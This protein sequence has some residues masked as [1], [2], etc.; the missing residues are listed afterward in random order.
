M[1]ILPNI[2]TTNIIESD[3]P[4]ESGLLNIIRL[5]QKMER[6]I[7]IEEDM[8]QSKSDLIKKLEKKCVFYKQVLKRYNITEDMWEEKDVPK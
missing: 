2:T 4:V 7:N 8:I 5:V 3:D 6:E 1:K